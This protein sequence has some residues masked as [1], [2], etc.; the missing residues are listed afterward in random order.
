MIAQVDEEAVVLSLQV[1][2]DEIVHEL[3]NV[4]KV[5]YFSC[6][7]ACSGFCDVARERRT[8]FRH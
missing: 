4:E 1:K 8:F 6:M 3:V 7:Q 5:K 2:V